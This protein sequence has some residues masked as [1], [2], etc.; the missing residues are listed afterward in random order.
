[1]KQEVLIT[2]NPKYVGNTLI[3]LDNGDEKTKKNDKVERTPL[4][5]QVLNPFFT[6]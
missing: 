5:K 4:K 6:K 2:G 3:F 1:M